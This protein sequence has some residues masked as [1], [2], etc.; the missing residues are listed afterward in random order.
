MRFLAVSL[1]LMSASAAMAQ[2]TAPPPAD[3]C[4]VSVN[5]L[6]QQR[7]EASDAAAGANIALIDARAK[8]EELQ[9]ALDAAKA[10]A[11]PPAAK[12]PKP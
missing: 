7:D 6:R 1:V 3:R 9:K 5:V 8:I 11:H 2:T 12:E 4:L 10:A